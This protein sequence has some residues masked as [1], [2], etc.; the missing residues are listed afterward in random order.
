MAT[1]AT[2]SAPIPGCTGAKVQA[3]DTVGYRRAGERVLRHEARALECLAAGL[4]DRF[5]QAVGLLGS[6]GGRVVVTGMGKSGHAAAKIA[7]T[8][9]S[10]GTPA[11]FVHAAEAGHGDLGMIAPGDAVVAL[12]NSGATAEMVVI[13]TYARRFHIPVVAI[14]SDVGSRLAIAADV[15]LLLPNVGEA[16]PLGLAPTTSTTMMIGLGDALAV[17][18]L[19][20]RGFSSDDFRILHPGGRLGVR[21]L[22]VRDLM[23]RHGDMPLVPA[24]T[25]MAEAI[26]VMSAKGFGVVGIVD[27]DG[28][29]AGIITD[30]DLRR[31]MDAGLLDKRVEAVM[32]LNPKTIRPGALAAEALAMMNAQRPFISVLFVVEDDGYPLGLIRVHDC[33][34]AGVA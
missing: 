17:A 7:A 19:E 4:D 34:S 33:L 18:L 29:L 27:H 23:H 31:H 8:L 22:C 26:I 15:H 10:T 3:S 5:D 24:G 9:A 2:H 21:L 13:A 6:V 14:T 11:H 30:G 16:C 20:R 12:S 1:A 25:R 28:R 32:T